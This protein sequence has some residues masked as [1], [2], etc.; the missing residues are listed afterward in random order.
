MSRPRKMHKP[1]KGGFNE[2][3]A[4]ALMGILPRQTPACRAVSSR[5][6]PWQW[7]TCRAEALRKRNPSEAGS[8]AAAG[9]QLQSYPVKASQ[10]WS[11]RFTASIVRAIPDGGATYCALL[12]AMHNQ[13]WL[14]PAADIT[15]ASQSAIRNL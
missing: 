12:A 15:S 7:R 9:P 11:N 5:Q 13:W 6:S 1:L 2:I 10:S 14:A 4:A 8:E 3:I